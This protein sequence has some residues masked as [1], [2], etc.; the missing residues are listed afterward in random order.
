VGKAHAADA[1]TPR[2][3]RKRGFGPNMSAV[4][5]FP[6]AGRIVLVGPID[7]VTHKHLRDA[8]AR[9]RYT[10]L[11]IDSPGGSIE[12][13]MQMAVLLEQHK[14]RLVVDG[15]C[16]SACASFLFVAAPAKRVLHNSVVGIHGRTFVHRTGQKAEAFSTAEL[17]TITDPALRATADASASQMEAFHLA[18]RIKLENFRAFETY[19]KNRRKIF[20]SVSQAGNA[21][22]PYIGMWLLDQKQLE[23]MGVAGI[24]EF[25]FP[26]SGADRSAVQRQFGA[27][28]KLF[29]GEREQLDRMC[30]G[31]NAVWPLYLF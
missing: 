26:R 31:M 6:G 9:G 30:T 1:G 22:C 7:E 8:L 2:D 11:W 3:F 21:R 23:A 14:L 19:V 4:I 28:Y 13:A 20:A 12:I 15:A 29:Y 18:R 27:D 5:T 10:E 17:D 16:L 25:W 24:E